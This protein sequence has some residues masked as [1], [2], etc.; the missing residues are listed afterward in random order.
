M[1]IKV[2]TSQL[3]VDASVAAKWFLTDEPD[4]DLANLILSQM[5]AGILHLHAPGV[6]PH[7]VRGLLTRACLTRFRRGGSPRLSIDEAVN[8]IQTMNEYPIQIHEETVETGP[9]A[10]RM[11]VKYS[12]GHFDMT[13]LRLAEQLDCQWCTADEKI[14]SGVPKGFPAHRVLLLS[15]LR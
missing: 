8:A 6:F 9:E 11:A 7:E 13:Y 1:K 4:I 15:A 2:G 10:L 5:V 14:L 12:K 3:I